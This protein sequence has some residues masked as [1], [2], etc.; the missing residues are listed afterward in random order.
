MQWM[1]ALTNLIYHAMAGL[2][3]AMETGREVEH[4]TDQPSNQ[5]FAK[6]HHSRIALPDR[7][8]HPAIRNSS[9]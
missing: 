2:A 8:S 9:R 1:I 6:P 7:R 3:V 4:K 5:Q